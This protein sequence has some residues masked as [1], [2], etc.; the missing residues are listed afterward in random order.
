MDPGNPGYHVND[1]IGSQVDLL[2]T[3][4]DLLGL[5]TPE[6]QLYQGASLYSSTAQTDRTIYLNSFQ[7]YGII[8]G[9]RYLCGD[10]ETAQTRLLPLK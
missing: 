8:E 1:T 7:Q 10:R 2:P 5:P 4:L 3:I 9:H 6:N